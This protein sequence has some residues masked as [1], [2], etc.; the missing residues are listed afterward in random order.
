MNKKPIRKLKLSKDTLRELTPPDLKKANGGVKV[1]IPVM[2]DPS[3]A[4][5]FAP[6]F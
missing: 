6:C 5:W 3:G 1:T 4:T 2:C